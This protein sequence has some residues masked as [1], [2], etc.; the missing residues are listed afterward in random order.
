MIHVGSFIVK[1]HDDSSPQREAQNNTPSVFKIQEIRTVGEKNGNKNRSVFVAPKKVLPK[2]KP[3]DPFKAA[4]MLD[5][6]RKLEKITKTPQKFLKPSK[7]P[8][9]IQQIE[10][11]EPS[12]SVTQVMQQIPS[13]YAGVVNSSPTLSKTDVNVRV[14]MPEGVKEDELNEF[15]LMFYT[16]QKRM[17]VKYV[18]SIILQVR[19]FEKTHPHRRI[20]PEGKHVMTG[21]VV[22]DKE[23][24]IK[25]IKMVRWTNV[26]D[27]QHIFEDALKS[28]YSLP[29]PPKFLWEKNGEFTVFYNFVVNNI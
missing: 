12:K 18:E 16:F 24:N 20:F 1:L 15:E 19:E 25:Q 27:L 2:P 4:A 23:G 29:N 3:I 5:Q 11:N 26:D 14:E 17:M 10:K 6:P 7:A 22:F 13:S 21:R 9:A 28:M 8:T